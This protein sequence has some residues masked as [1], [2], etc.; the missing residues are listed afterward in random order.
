MYIVYLTHILETKLPD[1]RKKRDVL[2]IILNL[3]I[4]YVAFLSLTP[5]LAMFFA[6]LKLEPFYY[7][8]QLILQLFELPA[9]EE[10]PLTARVIIHS[11]RIVLCY[12]CILETSR[13]TMVF[14]VPAL[15]YLEIFQ[16]TLKVIRKQYIHKDAFHL[17]RELR[18]I[19]NMSLKENRLLFG[20]NLA[21]AFVLGVMLNCWNFFGWKIFPLGVYLSGIPM[22][23][24]CAS[25]IHLSVKPGLQTFLMSSEILNHTWQYQL[26]EL[27][28]ILKNR[29]KS[30]G[31][32]GASNNFDFK[33]IRRTLRS[34]RVI[35][36]HPGG[37]A[38]MHK[39]TRISF[40]EYVVACTI[41]CLL[42]FSARIKN[43]FNKPNFEM[44]LLNEVTQVINQLI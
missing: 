4:I 22:S 3:I 15:L 18:V 28:T 41:D 38:T 40:Y 44:D 23:I 35:A 19:Q 42:L 6:Y 43:G 8:I 16:K 1:G 39:E 10:Q 26:V 21:I 37:M 33:V 17:Y 5:F 14:I 29:D 31:V 30:F 11:V 2:G 13:T 12:L 9:I 25:A 20:G 34:Q 36:F 27:Y 32:I 24:S 7:T